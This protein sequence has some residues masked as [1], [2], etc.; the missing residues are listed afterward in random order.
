[1]RTSGVGDLAVE[2]RQRWAAGRIWA[3]RQA[4]YLSTALLA[5]EPVVVTSDNPAASSLAA[6]PVDTAWHV[7]LDPVVLERTEVP[8]LGFWL[9]HQ[10]SHLLRSHAGRYPMLCR[11]EASSPVSAQSPE[12]RRWNIAGDAEINDDLS[13]GDLVLPDDAITPSR[14]GCP[15]GWVAEQ[16]WDTLGEHPLSKDSLVEGS[17]SKDSLVEGPL[18]KYSLG[19]GSLCKGS[20][21]EGPP[22]KYS[23]GE[24]PPS[25]YSLG[26]GPPGP[27]FALSESTKSSDCGSGCDGLPRPW[28]CGR[29][30]LGGAGQ[31]LV[32][33]DAAQRIREHC[34]QR[35]DVPAGWQRW[36]DDVLEPAV[37]WKR[38]LSSAVRRGM[39]DVAGRVDFSYRRPSRRASVVPDVVLPSLR[40]PLPRV[41]L[42]LD[43]SG[44]MSDQMLGQALAEV[45][46]VL[47]GLGVGRRHLSVVCCDATAYEAQRVLEAREVRLLGGG[48]TDMGAGLDAATAL[49]PRPDLVVVLTDGHTP[50]PSAAPKG[51]RVIVGLMDSAG[52]VPEWATAIAIEPAASAAG[53]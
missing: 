28:D 48:G 47:R 1:M 32:A 43:T 30:G 38:V 5:L 31:K 13:A 40:Q 51:V 17:L 34:R 20:L 9:V 2:L 49:K 23:L 10:V 37:S 44:S 21:G 33:R 8:T 19:E 50:W 42:V 53:W 35:G 25:K 46:G 7:Y 26:E 12:Q 15:D 22:S 52:R 29:P 3:A 6:F 4:P 45:G 11:E 27:S 18:S 39:A 36:A 14:I 24:G 16:Y 41:A